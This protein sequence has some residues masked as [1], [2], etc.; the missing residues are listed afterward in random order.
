MHECELV[1]HCSADAEELLSNKVALS[2]FFSKYSYCFSVELAI[3]AL[4][5]K[6]FCCREGRRVPVR[7]CKVSG[8]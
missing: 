7:R 5:I 4:V 1:I 3:R 8:Y 6:V 2:V